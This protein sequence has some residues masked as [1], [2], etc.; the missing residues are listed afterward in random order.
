MSANIQTVAFANP[1]DPSTIVDQQQIQR[2][3]AFAS[4][5]RGDSL[6]PVNGNGGAISWTQGLSKLA[7]ALVARG[8][9]KNANADI[10]DLAARSQN[11]SALMHYGAN[12]P[13]IDPALNPYRGHQPN[14]STIRNGQIG[15]GSSARPVAIANNPDQGGGLPPTDQVS[16][17]P[18]VTMNHP[19]ATVRSGG[20][21]PNPQAIAA[22]LQDA[23]IDVS[24]SQP[25]SSP[26]QN[27]AP[28][29]LPSANAQPAAAGGT[30]PPV[31]SNTVFAANGAP[32]GGEPMDALVP[33]ISAREGMLLQAYN[34]TS[35]WQMAAA[36]GTPI[37]DVKRLIQSGIDPRSPQGQ[38]LLRAA[39]AKNMETPLNVDRRGYVSDPYTARVVAFHPTMVPGSVPVF[40]GQG[41]VVDARQMPSVP[42]IE[43]ANSRATAVGKAYGQVQP[44]WDPSTGT[45]R[46]VNKGD[47]V[48]AG[49]NGPG[50]A[51]QAQPRPGF[52]DAAVTRAKQSAQ[53]YSN[54]AAAAAG[55]PD[56]IYSLTSMYQL[57]KKGGP[58]GPGSEAV[59]NVAGLINGIAKSVGV[60]GVSFNNKNVTTIGEFNKFANRYAAQIAKD[61]GLSG[62][63]A[64]RDMIIHGNPNDTLTP[65]ALMK[66][67]PVAMGYEM[68]QRGLAIAGNAYAKKYGSDNAS[69]FQTQWSQTADPRIYILMAE[70]KLNP[71]GPGQPSAT[72]K[73][74]HDLQ[75]RNPADYRA[76]VQ[77]SQ[78][79]ASVGAL[80][81]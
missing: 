7:E 36:A 64:S 28:I 79:L 73:F 69:D 2:N 21:A 30:T 41:N 70:D 66:V 47:V 39:A 18:P 54:V 60:E 46:L 52:N 44:V 27:P 16:N 50:G 3:L 14:N 72:A 13:T 1:L 35:Y 43:Q 38:H 37:D 78:I 81:Q 61:M 23:G 11:A 22:A 80:P 25:G 57:V 6:Q 17:I 42:A 71:P 76:L 62:T 65:G 56:R 8:M 15:T 63:D 10:W 45:Y 58:F 29:P 67:I 26:P 19:N 31:S 9:Q 75:Q 55:A 40:D 53:W 32:A 12:A 33:T 49:A 34:P 20:R 5:L 4:A 51:Y 77:K 24:G 48:T 74:M 68:M 59:E